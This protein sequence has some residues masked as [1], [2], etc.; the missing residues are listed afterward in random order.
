MGLMSLGDAAAELHCS[1]RWL[2]DNLRAG[3]FPAKKIGRKWLL[4][5][6]DIAAI[7]QLCSVSPAASCPNTVPSA[8]PPSSMTKTTLRRL[9]QGRHPP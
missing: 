6:D 7:L 1:K 9:Q 4:G 8:V 3:R 5:S 2:A